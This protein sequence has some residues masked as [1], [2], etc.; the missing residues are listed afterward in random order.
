MK[1]NSECKGLIW[2]VDTRRETNE[3]NLY[4][5]LQPWINESPSICARYIFITLCNA[6]LFL[7]DVVQSSTRTIRSAVKLYCSVGHLDEAI[8]I[9]TF[10]R[11]VWNNHLFIKCKLTLRIILQESQVGTLPRAQLKQ[12]DQVTY[13]I[14]FVMHLYLGNKIE[15]NTCFLVTLCHYIP[16]L[17]R[18]SCITKR[19]LRET[20][21]GVTLQRRWTNNET[22]SRESRARHA[23]EITSWFRRYEETKKKKKTKKKRRKI[24]TSGRAIR[25][26][27]AECR[28]HSFN[29]YETD[30]IY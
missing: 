22:R 1:N 2:K 13:S 12:H 5:Y 28:Y 26:V 4:K 19:F 20:L 11:S 3:K 30:V 17:S 23:W 29:D 27:T 21:R 8:D 24:N 15:Q 7:S 6:L 16:L 14:L 9:S 25:I 18:V 10:F